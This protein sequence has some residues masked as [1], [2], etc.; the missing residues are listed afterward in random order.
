MSE[1]VVL[2]IAYVFLLLSTF[3]R[4]VRGLRLA[5][6]S[7]AAAFVIFGLFASNWT[8]VL[9]NLLIG[10]M[11]LYQHLRFIS[12]R[13]SVKLDDE[14]RDVRSRLFVDLDD[15][16]FNALWVLGETKEFAAGTP[17]TCAG[18]VNHHVY[19]ILDGAVAVERS[20]RSGI[21]MGPDD[22]VGEFSFSNDEPAVATVWPDP[23]VRVRMWDHS[24]LKTLYDLSPRAGK[25]FDQFIA[26]QLITKLN[27]NPA[28][29]N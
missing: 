23:S 7:A 15:F 9:W 4:T 19:L 22:L 29:S 26:A 6:M 3:T 13:R 27:E 20:D 2:N 25:A 1:T 11:H 28:P 5:L 14:A 24:R 8:I 21:V 10:S 12:A 18:E 16:D 17:L